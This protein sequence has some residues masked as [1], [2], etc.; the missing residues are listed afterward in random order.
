MV[1]MENIA[2]LITDTTV[3]LILCAICVTGLCAMKI[4]FCSSLGHQPKFNKYIVPGFPCNGTLFILASDGLMYVVPVGKT[5]VKT[6]MVR[7]VHCGRVV[8]DCDQ[9]GN[10]SY[11][12]QDVDHGQGQQHEQHAVDHIANDWSIGSPRS[13][14]STVSVSDESMVAS[15]L[16][17]PLRGEEFTTHVQMI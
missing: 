6:D 13:Q 14:D 15:E 16:L 1:E 12:E 17:S 8:R 10:F 4:S 11:F 3:A 9:Y 7:E 5:V 2:T